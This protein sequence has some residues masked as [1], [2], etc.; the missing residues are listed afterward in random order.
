MGLSAVIVAVRGETP[1]VLTLGHPMEVPA[2]AEALGLQA[3]SAAVPAQAESGPGGGEER[4]AIPFGPLDP[5]GD[6]TLELGLRR[7][8]REQTKAEP[9]YLEQL[10]TFADRDRSMRGGPRVISV[11]YLALAR[12]EEVSGAGEPRWVPWYEYF[13]WEDWRGGRPG[14][15]EDLVRPA[16][17]D[18][19]C[20]APDAAKAEL[21]RERAALAFGWGST[22]WD[23]NRV[24]DRYE[25]LYEARLVPEAFS[26]AAHPGEEGG[27]RAISGASPAELG[28]PMALDHRRILATAMERLRGKLS[29]RPVVF[30]LL[31]PSFTLLRLQ[32]VVEALAGDALHKQNF[33][34]L[35]V[36]G[37]L[38]EATGALETNTGGRP[39]ELFSF[40]REV[41][42]ER[43]APGL[44]LPRRRAPGNQR[45]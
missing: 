38:V 40:R 21:R 35:V 45:P 27:Y 28:R 25:L 42:L 22:P 12:E 23:R 41:L 4:D 29:Y 8:I 30:E 44:G 2:A 14:V 36:S 34:R 18:W 16:L 5:E 15:L 39:A 7:W 1:V 33:R 19:A 6:R 17:E 10:Y 20:A 3:R 32:R 13:P 24:L 31:A 37:G 9:G 43:P 26:G 11:A